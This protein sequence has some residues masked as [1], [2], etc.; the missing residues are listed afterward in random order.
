MNHFTT[1]GRSTTWLVWTPP[2][3]LIGVQIPA[4][5]L[6]NLKNKTVLIT[7]GSSGIGSASAIAFAK[8]GANV[9]ITYNKTK[10][11]GEE[12]LKE[13]RKYCDAALLRLDVR[14]DESLKKVANDVLNLF[15]GVDILVNNAGIALIKDFK[16]YSFDD[17][18]SELDTNLTGPLKLTSLLLHHLESRKDAVIINIASAYSKSVDTEV[19]VYCASKFG[20]HGFTQALALEL[21]PNVRTY[22]VN[23]D[24]TATRMTKFRGT[25]V[26]KVADL[27]VKTAEE[28]LGKKSGE[29]VDVKDFV[30]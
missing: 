10:N 25:P 8:K 15:G 13:C 9:I 3:R 22:V 28:S 12:T 1:R 24:L 6:M 4:T 23:P 29:D 11:G 7:G 16:K 30:K 18:E 26:E 2:E 19:A 27:I 5:P 14:Y 20:L 17:I 21:P